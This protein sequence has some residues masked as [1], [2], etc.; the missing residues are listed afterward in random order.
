MGQQVTVMI[1][2]VSDIPRLVVHC[3]VHDVLAL[4]CL[5]IIF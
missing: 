3:I 2:V 4:I 1:R 5:K